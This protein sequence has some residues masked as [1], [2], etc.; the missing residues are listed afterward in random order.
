[1]K[2]LLLIIALLFSMPAWADADNVD[3]NSFFC[4]PNNKWRASVA[5][6]FKNGNAIDYWEDGTSTNKKYVA[7]ATSIG[8]NYGDSGDYIFELSRKNLV[9]NLVQ[10]F[11]DMPTISWQCKFMDINLAKY[12]LA[13]ERDKRDKR[14]REGNKF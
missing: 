8:W 1:M 9:L 14:L 12:K 3:G 6:E 2:P 5:V 7:H 4:V 11:G 10:N 13:E